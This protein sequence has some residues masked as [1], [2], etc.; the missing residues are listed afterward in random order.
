MVLSQEQI[1]FFHENGYLKTEN[2]IDKKR[3]D[4][5]SKT[6]L[7]LAKKYA[8]N[9][10]EGISEENIFDNQK[11]HDSMIKLKKENI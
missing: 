7:M 9:Y 5:V 6:M 1:E 3:V 2:I 10:F 11:F 8:N 4:V